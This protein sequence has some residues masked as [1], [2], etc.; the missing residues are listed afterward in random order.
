MTEQ[1]ERARSA[2]AN[3][4]G[5][6]DASKSLISEFAKT[7]FVGYG[8]TEAEAKVVAIIADDMLVDYDIPAD[9]AE[10]VEEAIEDEEPTDA[11]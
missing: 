2:R 1:K 11:E 10:E 7:E 4:S 3:I 6:S 9:D 8:A 5:W